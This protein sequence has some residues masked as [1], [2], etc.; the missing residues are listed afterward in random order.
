MFKLLRE[1]YVVGDTLPEA[2]HKALYALYGAKN[3]LEVSLTM[4]VRK[5]F[6]EPRISRLFPGGFRE[7]EQYRQ[8][9]MDGILDFE[10]DRGNWHYTYHRRFTPYL[11]D[12]IKMLQEDPTSRRAVIS[13]R[14]NEADIGSNDPACLQSIQFMIR[15]KKLHCFVLFR[16]ND[17]V[18]A[19]FMNAFALTELQKYVA[20][21]LNVK[22]GHYVHRANSFHCYPESQETLEGYIK[23][24][25]NGGE[26]TY[27]YTGHWDKLME[28]AKPEIAAMV[29]EQKRKY[30]GG[31]DDC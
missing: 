1:Y 22:I 18:R 8:E 3:D 9:M 26:L 15:D 20:D 11:E 29:A 12:V 24:M 13:I 31:R 17:G 27:N 21:R 14:D 23:R 7:L 30:E 2:Y 4:E 10:V 16:S 19:A 6:L 5:P 25:I 28:S